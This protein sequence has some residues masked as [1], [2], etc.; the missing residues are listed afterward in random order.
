MEK[1]GEPFLEA[2]KKNPDCSAK[3][4]VLFEFKGVGRKVADCVGLLSL[5]C[6]SFIPV[7][8]HVH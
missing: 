4:N 7:D 3:R 5:N 1:G 8:T 2:L 6:A